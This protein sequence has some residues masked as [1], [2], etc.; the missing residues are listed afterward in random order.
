MNTDARTAAPHR[1]WQLLLA[2]VE[3]LHDR[4]LTGIRAIPSY[5]PVGY[6]RLEVT[7]ADNLC[8]GVNLPLRD[9]DT[10][11]RFSAGDFPRVGKIVI[12]AG[13]TVDEVADELRRAIGSPREA[14]YFNDAEYCDW[15]ARMRARSEWIGRPPTG[16]GEYQTGWRCGEEEIAPPPGWAL[17]A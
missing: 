2:A 3:R 8:D 11:L 16:F 12:D 6:W 1:E 13:T 5:G 9:E 10:S 4:G 7:T 15:F 14:T 17:P